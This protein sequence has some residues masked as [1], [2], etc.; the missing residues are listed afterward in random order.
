[1]TDETLCGRPTCECPAE[2]IPSGAN[3]D[4]ADAALQVISG[5]ADDLEEWAQGGRY[6][7]FARRQAGRLREHVAKVDRALGFKDEEVK[8]HG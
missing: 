7:G 2:H 3:M 6:R 8:N 5:I 1:M 4:A